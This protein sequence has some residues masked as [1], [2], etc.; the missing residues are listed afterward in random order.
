[1]KRL[2]GCASEVLINKSPTRYL[3]GFQN[4]E[5]GAI[6]IDRLFDDDFGDYQDVD[7]ILAP[8]PKKVAKGSTTHHRCQL[9][10]FINQPSTNEKAWCDF[11][12][13]PLRVAVDND[14][15][16]V[17]HIEQEGYFNYS[18]LHAYLNCEYKLLCLYSVMTK[19]VVLLL[20]PFFCKGHIGKL[21]YL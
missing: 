18:F 16:L 6:K 20:C 1:M 14:L 11:L 8:V 12:K 4:T 3:I 13:K 10:S 9:K 15:R 21:S 2:L 7:F 17:I 5:L 19:V